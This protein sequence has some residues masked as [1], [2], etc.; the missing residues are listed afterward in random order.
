M[1]LCIVKQIVNPNANIKVSKQWEEGLTL[2]IPVTLDIPNRVRVVGIIL[3]IA[4]DLDLFK[5]PGRQ[6]NIGRNKVT[7]K[8]FMPE[9]QACRQ[10]A[11]IGDLFSTA[12]DEVGVDFD[13]PVITCIPD[14]AISVPGDLMVL[15]RNGGRNCV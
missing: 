4:A 11:C 1:G 14:G 15:L 6:M 8:V 9:P 2:V 12:E 3:L 10:A 7:P 13:D 5:A